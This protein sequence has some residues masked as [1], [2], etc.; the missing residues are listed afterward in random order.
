MIISSRFSLPSKVPDRAVLDALRKH[1]P[2]KLESRVKSDRLYLDS[3]DWRVKRSGSLLRCDG[4]TARSVHL[5]LWRGDEDGPVTQ[6][7]LAARPDWSWELPG[8]E[9]WRK[10]RT[11]LGERRI[12]DRLNVSTRGE[13]VAVLDSQEKTIARVLLERHTIHAYGEP[14][15][16]LVRLVTVIPVRGYDKSAAAVSK[17]LKGAGLRPETDPLLTTSPG[18]TASRK[19]GEVSLDRTMSIAKAVSLVLSSLHEEMVANEAGVRSQLDTEF[20]HEYRVA[21]RCARSVLRQVQDLVPDES[22]TALSDELRWLGT[23]TGPARDIDVHLNQLREAGSEVAPLRRLLVER[24]ANAH[25][26]LVAALDSQRYRA[27][28]GSWS[29]LEHRAAAR[30]RSL[31]G[32]RPAGEVVDEYLRQAHRRVLKAG[33]A[34]HDDSPAEALHDVRKKAK[35]LRYLLETFQT[36]YPNDDWR[37]VVTELKVLQDNL[38]EFQDCQV[39]AA[40]LRAMEE[41]LAREGA[42]IVTIVE[43]MTDHLDERQATARAAFAQ[44]F[45]RFSSKG[46]AGRMKRLYVA[47]HK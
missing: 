39:Q 3:I 30:S 9:R 42:S 18:H 6:V 38:G 47:R 22:A 35:A 17:V 33:T 29:D 15:G 28:L 23:L 14:G 24:R 2:I 11:S 45:K 1:W 8:E 7:D 16:R 44:R 34:V 36:L 32:K 46:V 26:A 25:E 21:G 27:L 10:V 19:A 31:A 40:E 5:T 12:L 41:D 20:L 43:G 37:A 13:R 4:D